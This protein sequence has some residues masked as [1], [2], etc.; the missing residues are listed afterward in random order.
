MHSSALLQ[1]R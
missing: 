1:I